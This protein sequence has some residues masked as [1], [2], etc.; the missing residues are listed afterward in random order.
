M[1]DGVTGF[2]P[3]ADGDATDV[4]GDGV[5]EDLRLVLDD[6]RNRLG[7]TGGADQ[8]R[9]ILEFAVD[10]ISSEA[11]IESAVLT[12]DVS[13]I[14]DPGLIDVEVYA[15]AGNGQID[16]ADALETGTLVG[17]FTPDYSTTGLASYPI[18]L[19]TGA[20]QSIVDSEDHVGLVTLISSANGGEL[21]YHS[22][23]DLG[24]ATQPILSLVLAYAPELT[25]NSLTITEGTAVTL[26]SGDLSATDIDSDD[27]ALTFSVSNIQGGQFLVSGVAASSFT[28]ADVSAGQVAFEHDN[29]E[30]HCFVRSHGERRNVQRRA[31]AGHC[32]VH[33]RQRQPAQRLWRTS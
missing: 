6:V 28:Q 27:A 18:I 7:V 24:A 9:G 20:I 13:S 32:H 23:E 19:D 15:Y 25:D 5:F 17:A 8:S 33:I 29:S 4:D 10:T 2:L 21:T 16:S 14:S 3:V 30:N 22:A 1:D 26:G 31:R 12:L 11:I